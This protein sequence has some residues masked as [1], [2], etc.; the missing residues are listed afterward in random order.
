MA[1]KADS[2]EVAN[3]NWQRYIRARDAGHTDYIDIAKKCNNFYMGEQWSQKDLDALKATGRPALTINQILP[4]INAILGEQANKRLDIRFL[5][6]EDGDIET[7]TVLTKLARQ[8]S[9]SNNLDYV[10]SQVFADG[11]IEERGYFDIRMD[12]SNNIQGDIK[13]TSV[14]PRTVVLDPDAREY[15]PDTWSDVIV[16]KWMTLNEIELTYGKEKRKEVENRVAIG[17]TQG[18]DSVTYITTDLDTFGDS[19]KTSYLD[20]YDENG[21]K[22]GKVRVID[23]QCKRIKKIRVFVDLNTGDTRPVPDNWSEEKV[24][25]VRKAANLQITTKFQE[26]IR[27]TVTADNVV[28]HDDWSP[29]SHYTIVPYFPYFRRGKPFGVVRNLLSPQEQYN[30]VKS[31]EL[32]IVN[33]TANSGYMVE[34]GSLTNM[35]VDDLAERGAETG[36]VVEYAPNA[37]PPNKI[38]PN[39]I[40]TGLD[41]ISQKTAEDIKSISGITDAMLGTTSPEVSGRAIEAKVSRGM[42]QVQVPFDNFNR[43]RNILARR[44]LTLIQ[45]YYTDHRIISIVDDV[46]PEKNEQIEINKPDPV[47]GEILNDVTLGKYDI[48]VS[49]VPSRNTYND[50]QFVEAMSMRNAGVAIP[51]W[52]PIQY[53]TLDNKEELVQVVKQMTG[54]APPTPEE[55]QLQQQQMQLQM[56]MQQLQLQEMQAKIQQLNSQAVL[57]Q[58]KAQDTVTDGDDRELE[59][60]KL[61]SEIAAKQAELET[62]LR[63]A[64]IQ[65]QLAMQ[66]PDMK[67]PQAQTGR[68]NQT[69]SAAAPGGRNN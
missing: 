50:T 45:A 48:V 38:Q 34:Q 43:S 68:Y 29:Y 35:T 55:A 8:I 51:D 18:N 33:S 20:T 14:D 66:K 15:D 58:A 67:G 54:M 6:N 63:I 61:Q 19:T 39:Q 57:N 7:A 60:L 22:I 16:S 56:Q 44:M 49:S 24:Q 3:K 12:F 27:W 26:R 1:K 9:T 25:A 41:R 64:G 2:I 21:R 5:P 47:T 69:R 17:D 37:T 36:L 42:I 53:S 62:K 30:K 10:E 4:T 52:V 46:E 32:H 59:V 31:Q 23:R 13:I 11:I 28:L 65:A 40:P